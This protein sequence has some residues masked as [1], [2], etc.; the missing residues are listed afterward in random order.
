MRSRV[1]V[2]VFGP[3]ETHSTFVTDE[4]VPV[5]KYSPMQVAES[6]AT[7]MLSSGAPKRRILANSASLTDNASSWRPAEDKPFPSR[8]IARSRTWFVSGRPKYR[9]GVSVCLSS[10]SYY[11]HPFPS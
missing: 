7:R 1:G 2:G 5:K 3:G 6:C 10:L 8:F 11:H 9:T 4:S